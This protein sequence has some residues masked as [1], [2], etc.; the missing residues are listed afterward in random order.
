MSSSLDGLDIW[1]SLKRFSD[2]LSNHCSDSF[3]GGVL[4]DIIAGLEV[5][6]VGVCWSVC[7][8]S[9]WPLLD[10]EGGGG[11]IGC[12]CSFIYNITITSVFLIFKQLQINRL[13]EW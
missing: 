4:L 1:L 13:F 8:L 9:T 5:P 10:D 7:C 11:K 3:G 12:I 6:D 2:V